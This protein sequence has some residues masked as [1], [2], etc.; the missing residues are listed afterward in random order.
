MVTVLSVVP[1]LICTLIL[2]EICSKQPVFRKQRI[3]Q[4][5]KAYEA[6]LKHH[7]K[8]FSQ[9][10][11]T[12][13][14]VLDGDTLE[15]KSLRVK[16]LD[17]K[18]LEDFDSLVY[19]PVTYANSM[20]PEEEIDSLLKYAK[21]LQLKIS[22]INIGDVW[23]RPVADLTQLPVYDAIA[24]LLNL[25]A[26][27][28]FTDLNLRSQ[29]YFLSNKNMLIWKIKESRKAADVILEKVNIFSKEDVMSKNIFLLQCF[30]LEQLTP[31]KRCA[32]QQEF[33]QL[34]VE[35]P[36]HISGAQWVSG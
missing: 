9:S 4:Q 6:T 18:A 22:Q 8:F 31:L 19:D 32:L 20:L 13:G 10:S 21:R 5:E 28:N 12:V 11:L 14:E 17:T 35:L 7:R 15:D 29:C 3:V 27:G 25:K 24:S 36:T 26:D 2:D 23:Y 33:F 16:Y 1:I 34:D 30:I